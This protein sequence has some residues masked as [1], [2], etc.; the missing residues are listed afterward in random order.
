MVLKEHTSTS[1][2]TSRGP[3]ETAPPSQEESAKGEIEQKIDKMY[4]ESR[5][6]EN[7]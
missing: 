6:S 1:T 5:K 2:K 3:G 7:G 4:A